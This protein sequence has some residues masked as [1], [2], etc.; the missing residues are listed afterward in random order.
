MQ[1]KRGSAGVVVVTLALAVGCHSG[2]PATSASSAEVVVHTAGETQMLT[3]QVADT[4]DLRAKGL[5]VKV[6]LDPSSGMAFVWAQP[7][8]S[9]FWMKD[10]LIPLSIAFWD[11][12][13]KIVAIREMTPCRADPCETYG[14][15]VAYVGAVEANAGWFA[16]HGAKVGDVIELKR[17]P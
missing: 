6:S 7:T 4:P 5:M 9:T 12:A 3:V 17:G 10:T 8:T 15:P 13:G 2:G 16:A 14:S 1:A 11:A